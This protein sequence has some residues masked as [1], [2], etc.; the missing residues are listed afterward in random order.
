MESKHQL[1]YLK[2]YSE[3]LPAS[4]SIQYIQKNEW[5]GQIIKQFEEEHPQNII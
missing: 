1:E 2:K 3:K 5:Y 4:N